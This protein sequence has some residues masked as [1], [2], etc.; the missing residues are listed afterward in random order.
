MVRPRVALGALL[1]T[2]MIA[3]SA[4]AGINFVGTGNA[5]TSFNLTTATINQNNISGTGA[6]GI[7]VSIGNSNTTGPGAT[8][9]IPGT[10]NIISITNNS[11]YSIAAAGTQAITVANSGG[12]G[13][14]R[15]RTN[16]NI[17]C[18]GKN[19]GGCT[20]PT[21]NPLGSS[22][23]GTVVLIGNNGFATM[24]G[25]VD[26]NIITA[27]HTPNLGGGN[28]IAGGNGVA[29][30]G[31]A[32][33][34]DLTLSVT[35]N[36]VSGTDGNGILLVGRGT[37]G[38][39][40]LKIQSNSVSTPVNAG[41]T[42]RQGIR[43]DAGNAS[44]AD[45]SVCLHILGNTTVG[46]NG[47]AGIGVRKQGAVA[48]T[49]DFGVQTV[50]QNPPSNTDIQNYINSQNP[51]STGTDIISGSNYAQCASAP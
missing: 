29:G 16:F 11:V 19:T 51:G 14:S 10:G 9:G 12:N 28:G 5:S 32:W 25:T 13:A 39:F 15:T 27:T 21:A 36:V 4:L 30:A 34:P 24:T 47:A 3:Q 26:N 38:V 17:S 46:S 1:S 42:A 2:L 37:S 18:N 43:V 22:S 45:D 7:Q 8:A 40:K 49:N 35:N 33:T 50:P 31:N 44:S 6:V 20:A 23:Q 41:G 48:T